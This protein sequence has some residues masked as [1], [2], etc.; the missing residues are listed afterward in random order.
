[1]KSAPS[2]YLIR[3]HPYPGEALS[4]WRQRSGWA[5]GYKLYPTPDERTRR[6]DSDLGLQT[7][8]ME[9]LAEGHLLDPQRLRSLTLFD[10]VGRVVADLNLRDQPRWWLRARYGN[11]AKKYGS[12]FCPHCLS[13]D[14]DPY[15]RLVWRFG[16]VTACVEHECG[17]LDHCPECL[18]PPWPSGLGVKGKLSSQFTS[19]AY[20]WQCGY[21]LRRAISN[22]IDASLTQRLIKGVEENFVQFGNEKTT[23]LNALSSLWATSQIFLRKSSRQWLIF[24]GGR[25]GA[26][27]ASLSHDVVT[28]KSIGGLNVTDRA[29]L[30]QGA[31]DVISAGRDSFVQFCR[32]TQLKRMH[33]DGA[34]KVQPT[35]MTALIDQEL[36]T[37][38]RP[39]VSDSQILAFI[40]ERKKSKGKEPYKYELRDKYGVHYER[41][42]ADLDEQSQLNLEANFAVFCDR[43]A[44]SLVQAS[45]ASRSLKHCA[46]DLTAIL[47]SLIDGEELTSVVGKPVKELD[48]RLREIAV[49]TSLNPR[50]MRLVI[51]VIFAKDE[52]ILRGLQAL[53]NVVLRQ[54]RKRRNNLMSHVN[55]GHSKDHLMFAGLA[56][57]A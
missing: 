46:A 9:W 40:E 45:Q 4:S 37:R 29:I 54:V 17:L 11:S 3:P 8:V 25:W 30:L 35:W 42:A 5:N 41:L 57:K 19:L 22:P 56:R 26:L 20:C 31:W 24:C 52:V 1:M 6:V 50:L 38:L 27:A 10:Y 34:D 48:E 39:A 49:R 18:H 53:P 15:F 36:P 28:E 51:E 12:M 43:V 23:A 13:M 2:G 47:V 21:D 55:A 44:H 33:F 7:G 16:F 14:P 32:E